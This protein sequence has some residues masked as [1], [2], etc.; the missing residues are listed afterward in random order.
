M[1][2]ET[3]ATHIYAY[4]SCTHETVLLFLQHSPS[5]VRPQRFFFT[6]FHIELWWSKSRFQSNLIAFAL[7]ALHRARIEGLFPKAP[8]VWFEIELLT[9]SLINELRHTYVVTKL[10]Y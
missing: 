6:T 9:L 2:Q 10:K 7:S 3:T 1:L 4:A 8:L 5:S